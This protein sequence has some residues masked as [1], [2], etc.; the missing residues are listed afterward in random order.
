MR[1]HSDKHTFKDLLH[2]HWPGLFK[3]ISVMKDRKAKEFFKIDGARTM[4]CNV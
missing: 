3:G 2:S 4:K 1:K